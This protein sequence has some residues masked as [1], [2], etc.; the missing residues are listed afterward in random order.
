[1]FT[2][3]RPNVACDILCPGGV[4]QVVQ[5][6]VQS[7]QSM[8]SHF[9]RGVEHFPV[10]ETSSLKGWK[11]QDDGRT[12]INTLLAR[13]RFPMS[14]SLCLSSF[15]FVK[16]QIAH[17]SVLMEGEEGA[18]GQRLFPVK[19]SESI[20][21]IFS[22]W[23]EVLLLDCQERGPGKVIKS[24]MCVHLK[25][26]LTGCWTVWPRWHF[27]FHLAS[28]INHSAPIQCD[29]HGHPLVL[30]LII[31]LCR[32]LYSKG[33][34]RQGESKR[35]ATL[36]HYCIY[37]ILYIYIWAINVTWKK[38]WEAKTEEKNTGFRNGETDLDCCE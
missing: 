4:K 27:I 30:A 18:R 8:L 9:T 31:P 7:F 22:H 34:V 26:T 12:D 33:K 25:Q 38:E 3:R 24:I 21:T 11:C 19:S 5:C 23:T 28:S 15:V 35:S 29:A 20:R 1:M 16:A 10:S 6:S 14:S 32:E 17:P 13:C 37:S 2:V 36:L